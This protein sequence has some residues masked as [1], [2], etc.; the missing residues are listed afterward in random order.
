MNSVE[1][2]NNCADFYFNSTPLQNY[3]I[4]NNIKSNNNNNDTPMLITTND[5]NLIYLPNNDKNGVPLGSC[6]IQNKTILNGTDYNILSQDTY[7]Y[8]VCESTPK[9]YLELC[10]I[11]NLENPYYCTSKNYTT[12]NE[13]Y[14]ASIRNNN[15]YKFNNTQNNTQSNN[16]DETSTLTIVVIIF[17]VLLLLIIV[18]IIVMLVLLKK[19]N[20]LNCTALTNGAA[21]PKCSCLNNCCKKDVSIQNKN[22]ELLMTNIMMNELP[23]GWQEYSTEHGEPYYYNDNTGQTQWERPSYQNVTKQ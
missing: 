19:A 17:A 5:N 7:R 18:G 1:T 13:K 14:F 2:I 6:C 21:C 20:K 8:G 12:L 11:C 22:N 3:N 23:P 4:E 9:E 10:E 16:N 15:Y